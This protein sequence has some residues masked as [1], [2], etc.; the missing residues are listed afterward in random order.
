MLEV[1]H[2]ETKTG[3]TAILA[4]CHVR[5]IPVLKA[6]ETQRTSS[7]PFQDWKGVGDPALKSNMEPMMNPSEIG[8]PEHSPKWGCS[9]T[10]TGTADVLLFLRPHTHAHTHRIVLDPLGYMAKIQTGFVDLVMHILRCGSSVCWWQNGA[11]LNLCSWYQTDLSNTL[12]ADEDMLGPQHQVQK[13]LKHP[14]FNAASTVC[15][16]LNG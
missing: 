16:V 13:H 5:Y 6:L 15:L 11:L 4:A 2:I 1:A 9:P 12:A 7:L 14:S 3:T 8:F 10:N